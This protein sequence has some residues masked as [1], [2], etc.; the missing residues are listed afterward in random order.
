[1]NVFD[2]ITKRKSVR[3]YLDKPVEKEKLL[4]VLEAA[5]LAPSAGNRQEWRIVVVTDAALRKKLAS[6]ATRHSFIGEAP[7]IL[8]CCAADT[9]HVMPCGLKSFAIDVAI[10]IDHMTLAAVEEG[11]GTCW[12]GG[13]D[14]S[15]VKK[16]LGIPDEVQVVELLPLGYPVDESAVTKNRMALD[17]IVKYERW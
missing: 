16:T 17:E 7:I 1:M 2:A 5:H 10:A 4:K 11:L 6:E 13:F 14:Q 9:D 12:I 15:V 3:A 8:A